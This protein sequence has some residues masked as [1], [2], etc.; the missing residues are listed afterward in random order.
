LKF[1]PINFAE[2]VIIS[3]RLWFPPHSV[4]ANFMSHVFTH[5]QYVNCFVA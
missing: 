3:K 4:T 5:L 2:T 1:Q